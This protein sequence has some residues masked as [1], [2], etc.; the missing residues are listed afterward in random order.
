M[1]ISRRTFL[2]ASAAAGAA[3]VAPA[4]HG[5]QK[6]KRY[7][8]ALI[9]SGWWGMNILRTA[10]AAGESNVVALADVDRN[11]L[12]PAAAEVEKLTGQAPKKYKDY[13]EL[14]DKEKPEI[15]IVATPDHWHALGAIAAAEHGAHVYV[16][17]PVS[18]T[19]LE[20]RAMVNAARASKTVMQVGTHR[21]VSPH[22]IS[23]QK[24]LKDGRAGKVGMV[25]AF[26]HYGG[27]RQRSAPWLGLGLLVRPGPLPA[28]QQVDPP[29]RLSTVPGLRQRPVGR[30]GHSLAGPGPV[31]GRRAM[32]QEGL[33]DRREARLARPYGRPRHPGRA[34]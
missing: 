18:H 30:L 9:G 27:A 16:E 29:P 10:I 13:R 26:V 33:L 4:L 22:N 24:F 7:R 32:A 15:A 5:A 20:G 8:T 21:R 12:D 25:R 23:A 17:K 2:A 14:L 34:L 19:I 28:V 11:Q 31:V 1:G 3:F 6:N